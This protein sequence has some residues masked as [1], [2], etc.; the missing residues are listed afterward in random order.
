LAVAARGLA[1][2]AR[3]LADVAGAAASGVA[4][5]AGAGRLELRR[6]GRLRGSE[7]MTP[8]SG[9]SV[10]GQMIAHRLAGR[11]EPSRKHLDPFL[12]WE[13]CTAPRTQN[14]DVDKKFD[15]TLKRRAL[16]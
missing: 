14:S 1:V 5:V 6:W 10:I 8:G 3:G 12:G 11:L 16:F 2:A 7:P 15:G 9:W 4:A 13:E